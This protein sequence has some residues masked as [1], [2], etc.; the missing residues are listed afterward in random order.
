M[1]IF[2]GLVVLAIAIAVGGAFYASSGP[3]EPVA[4]AVRTEPVGRGNLTEFVTAPGTVMADQNVQIS[5]KIAAQIVELPFEEGDQV[6]AGDPDA[7]PPVPASVLVRLDDRDLRGRLRAAEARQ[8]AQVASLAVAE[9]NLRAANSRIAATQVQLEAA[10]RDLNRLLSLYESN[11]VARSAVDDAQ[12]QYDQLA[13]QIE[14][15]Q[16]A[17]AADELNL[18]VLRAQIT[19][20]DAEIQQA[21]DELEYTVITAPIDGTI[22]TLNAEEGEIVVTGTMNNAGTVIME[23]ADLS[24]MIVEA[25][26]DETDVAEVE[27]GQKARVRAT[28]YGETSLDGTVRSVAL[29]QETAGGNVDSD[30]ESKSY[31]C[32]ILL[33]PEST[34][35][36]RIFSGLTA[37]VE[38]ETETHENVI[39]VPSQAVLGR[40]VDGLPED[41]R[42]LPQVRSDKE[43]TPV[44]YRLVDGKA[45]ATPVEVGPSDLRNTV[46]VSGLEEGAKIITG[47]YKELETLEHDAVVKE[48]DP[49]T[50]GSTSAS[51]DDE[52]SAA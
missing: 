24:R 39:R 22:T 8:A 23:V 5:A 37:D 11:D 29:A 38:I 17:L 20:A 41:L 33:D 10:E 6:T 31:V 47:P 2:I 7:N 50:A 9:A 36:V 26:V 28:A 45:V 25:E 40:R 21:R 34:A 49:P 46:I 48:G 12:S 32:E 19:A 52:E 44:V 30:M 35:K 4:T 14:S 3:D 1:K 13:R 51:G 16:A 43:F 42:N 18:E 27:V 15:E